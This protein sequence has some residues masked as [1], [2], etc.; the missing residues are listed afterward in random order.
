MDLKPARRGN[1]A[2]RFAGNLIGLL[3]DLE[4]ANSTSIR[5][6]SEALPDHTRLHPRREQ[7]T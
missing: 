7:F 6:V 5:N 3:F 1:Q 4:E 2:G